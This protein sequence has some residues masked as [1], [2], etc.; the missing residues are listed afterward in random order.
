MPCFCCCFKALLAAKLF[1]KM[2]CVLA[3][4]DL[5]VFPSLDDITQALGTQVSPILSDRHQLQVFQL[6]ASL[7]D[8]AHSWELPLYLFFMP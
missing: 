8:S 3:K 1:S 6:T 2:A 4:M 5:T 7:L